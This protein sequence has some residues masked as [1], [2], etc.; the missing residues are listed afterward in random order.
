[1]RGD[2][3]DSIITHVRA[4][5]PQPGVCGGI[6]NVQQIGLRAL[7]WGMTVRCNKRGMT[8]GTGVESVRWRG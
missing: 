1:M 7:R 6:G 8:R 5:L 3:E 2:R 4:I